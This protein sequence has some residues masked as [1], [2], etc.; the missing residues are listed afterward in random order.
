MKKG[1]YLVFVLILSLSVSAEVLRNDD[2][3][4][5]AAEGGAT[6]AAE[7]SGGSLEFADLFQIDLADVDSYDVDGLDADLF[8]VDL[9]DC[10]WDACMDEVYAVDP[11]A[12]VF[13]V[14]PEE[15]I[16]VTE[17][18]VLAFDLDGLRVSK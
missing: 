3:D 15:M 14:V 12:A 13:D 2:G 1:I 9:K 18:P 11:S 10:L 16:F 6:Q 4:L 7:Q 5:A 8:T 17:Q